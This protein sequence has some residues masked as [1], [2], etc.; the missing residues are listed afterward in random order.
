MGRFSPR[1]TVPASGLLE[2]HLSAL[3]VAILETDADGILRVWAGAAE[4][5]FG[6]SAAEVLGRPLDT[7]DLVHPADLALVETVIDRLRSGHERQRVHR[8]RIRTRTGDV[9][10]CEWTRI[11][12]GAHPGHRPA[13][14]SYVADVS[15]QIEAETAAL[16]ARADLERWLRANPEG[17]CGLDREWHVVHWNP[18]AERM[19]ERS[20]AEVLGRDLWELF[21]EIRNTSFHRAFE[22][23]LA[24]GHLR[25]FEDRGARGRWYGVTAVPF[26]RGLYVFFNDITGR[27]QLEREVLSLDAA[28]R[29][30][31]GA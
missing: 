19:L 3:P 22:D 8:S 15:A 18:A 30:A 24:D 9:R 2:E 11:L 1:P 29:R 10:H 13:I 7:L 14:L 16:T 23:A 5:I 31:V 26:A 4:R 6:W 20:R 17:C 28:A 27:R 25:A 21:P 12:L